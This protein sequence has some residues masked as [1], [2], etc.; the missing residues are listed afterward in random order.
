MIFRPDRRLL[1]SGV[2][3]AALAGP[4]TRAGAAGATRPPVARIEPVT[5]TLWGEAIVDPYRW[6]ENA[7]D[8]AVQAF[9][10]GQTDYARATL[11]ASP[12]RAGLARR[13]AALSSDIVQA[14]YPKPAAGLIFYE[15]RNPGEAKASLVVRS[16]AGAETV[17]VDPST[18]GPSAVIDWWEPAPDGRHLAFGLS[19]G[20]NEASTGHVV[21]VQGAQLLADSIADAPYAAVSW[22]ADGTG[23]FYNRFAGRPTSAPDYYNDRSVYLHRVGTAQAQDVKIIAPGFDPAVPMRAISSPEIQNG[24]GSSHVAL[25]VRDGYVR[26]FDLYLADRA[27]VLAGRANWRRISRAS[28]G[29]ADFAMSGGHL[30]LTM[31]QGSPR[32]RLLKLDAAKGTLATAQVVRPQEARV[33]D[34]LNAGRDG[35]FV[36]L[37]DGGEQSLVFVRAEGGE[38]PVAIPF[39]GWMQ[40]VAI[41]QADG[42]ALVRATSWLDP[43]GVFAVGATGAQARRL[44]LQPPPRVDLSPY[45]ALRLYATAAD[46]TKIP[47]S[48]VAR[49]GSRAK[50]PAPCLVHV[51]GAYQWPSQPN[52]ILREV[53]FL[54]AEGVIATAHVRGGG[55]YGRAWHEAGMQ[56]SKPNTWRDLIACCELLV[57]QGWTRPSRLAIEGGSAGGIAVGRALT[58]RPDLF[59]AVLSKVGMSNP[60]RAEFEPNGQPNVPEFGSVKTREGFQA[61]KAMDSF[62]AVKDGVRYP[63]VMLETGINDSRVEPY[64]AAKM[65]ARLQAAN[66]I[67]MTLLRVDYDSGHVI[68]GRSKDSVDQEFTDDFTF[69][70]TNMR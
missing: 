18:F 35:V 1:L 53:A 43:A 67:G 32:G 63:A 61:L 64:N 13:V 54:E 23:F 4:A 9:M 58:E 19:A 57:A 29:V 59:A 10:Q 65:A 20:G 8:P 70:L 16:A 27:A 34:E 62:H 47:I 25:L 38:T 56:A 24:V 6:M 69:I 41:S 52:F 50:G 14:T 39:T 55:E 21:A 2:A 48:L 17:L 33:I 7:K 3:A 60:L 46:G 31:T 30:F 66:P 12:L 5:D 45:E 40:S 51:Y 68:A 28:D 42:Q 22:L 15:R 49:K 36:T 37:N 11:D 44:D 26:D